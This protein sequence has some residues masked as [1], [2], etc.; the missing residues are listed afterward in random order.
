MRSIFLSAIL[1]LALISCNS[2]AD[3]KESEITTDTTTIIATPASVDRSGNYVS[4]DYANRAKGFD[5]VAVAV[6]NISGDTV[7]IS[8]RSRADKKKPTCTF[9]AVAHKQNDST[10][11]AVAQGKNI[12]FT[13]SG[14]NITIAAKNVADSGV[15]NY[16]CSGGGTLAGNYTKINEPLDTTQINKT[17]VK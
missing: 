1:F 9:D 3:K 8:V 2:N 6:K 12:L 11:V 15:L 10:Y 13:F 16:F 5:W 14:D 17:T 7:S 4:A